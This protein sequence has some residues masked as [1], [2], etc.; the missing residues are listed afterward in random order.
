[1]KRREGLGWIKGC[2]L[3]FA[4]LWWFAPNLLL[5]QRWLMLIPAGAL[6]WACHQLEKKMD[7]QDEQ[8][9]Y[10]RNRLRNLERQ[11]YN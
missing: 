8:I 4:L 11:R 9:E 10:I 3:V 6:W 1:M 2:A 5:G 7:R